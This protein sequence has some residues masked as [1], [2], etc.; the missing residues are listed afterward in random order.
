MID[1]PILVPALEKPKFGEVCN[2]CGMCCLH[3]ACQLSVEY[4]KSSVAPCVALE[5]DGQRFRCG[6]LTDPSKYLGLK[7]DGNAE[8]VPLIA[9]ALGAGKGCDASD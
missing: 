8:L 3:E 6:L 2:G 4:L 1:F 7:F 9:E 5:H